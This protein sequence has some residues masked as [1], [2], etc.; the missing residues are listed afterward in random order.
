MSALSPLQLLPQ[1]GIQLIVHNVAGSSRVVLDGVD[2]NSHEY[3]ALLKPLLWVCRSFRFAVY[4]RYCNNFELSLCDMS[5]D[6]LEK[7][8]LGLGHTSV[9]YRMLNY[10][11]YSTHRLAKDIT[12]FLEER[13]VY[14]GEALEALSRLLCDVCPF[15]L[16]R[17]I[18][19]VFVK[20]ERADIDMDA[21]NDPLLAGANID[22]FVG[23]IKQMA[24]SVGEIGVQPVDRDSTP[25]VFNQHF[26][27]LV[28]QLYR[29]ASRVEYGY[30]LDTADLMRLQLGRICNL[31]HVTYVSTSRTDGAHQFVQLAQ[32]NALTLQSLSFKCGHE[33][34][35]SDLVQHA[36]G[37]PVAYPRLLTLK[38]LSWSDSDEP[39][40]PVFRG[41]VPFPV[42]WQ[43]YIDT[44]YPFGDNTLF[45]GNAATLEVLHMRLD[46][47]SVSILREYK[48]F[49]SGS[50]PK[51]Q[52]V[53]ISL[54]TNFVLELLAST[55]E[56]VDF[57]FSIGSGAAVRVYNQVT[58]FAN[59]AAIFPSLDSHACIQVLSLPNWCPVFWQVITLIESLP[60]LSDLQTSVPSLGLMPDGVTMY[61]LPE[62]MRLDYAPMGRRFRCWHLCSG[63]VKKFTELVNCVLLLALACPNFDYG[64]LPSFQRK[65]FMEQMERDIASDRFKPYAP[66]LRRL[67]FK[68]WQNC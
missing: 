14:S 27:N 32:K 34:F 42:L 65:L 12:V 29:L 38:L 54:T 10:L 9:D 4:S 41:A 23:R 22:A 68:G 20:D 56:A 3:K 15:P 24:P 5:V 63:H 6:S 11:G 53:N 16:A 18:L 50:H 35:V 13:A 8:Y 52:V 25:S 21:W 39:R 2:A 49:V 19:F 46:H 60:L 64:A 57:I 61:R 58:P 37:C 51:L 43:L 36:D 67:L 40:R 55:S 45:R 1:H 30:G 48:V 17:K 66:R 31:T 62:H 7:Q 26:S 59:P 33:L 44:D 28:S 47:S